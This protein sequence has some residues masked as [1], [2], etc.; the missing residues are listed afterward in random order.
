VRAALV[1]L[2][3]DDP[4]SGRREFSSRTDTEGDSLQTYITVLASRANGRGSAM[5][6]RKMIE[7]AIERE[8]DDELRNAILEFCSVGQRSSQP[9]AQGLTKRLN[10][11]LAQV[12]NGN[13]R[14]VAWYVERVLTSSNGG[15]A[16][17]R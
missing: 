3:Q 9:T 11:K 7:I 16:S 1:W 2:D 17:S 10:Q 6:A 12:V 15:S 5:T 13:Q 14:R 4:A 8:E